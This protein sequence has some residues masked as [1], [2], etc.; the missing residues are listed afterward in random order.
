MAN[1][2]II[3]AGQDT[4]HRAPKKEEECTDTTCYYFG[5]GQGCMTSGKC[6]YE[7]EEEI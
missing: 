2:E 4:A 7:T 3:G 6:V 5:E 1:Y